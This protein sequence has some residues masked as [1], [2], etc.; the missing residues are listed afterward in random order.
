MNRRNG[1]LY[2]IDDK[3]PFGR[4]LILAIQHALTMFGSTVAVPL[5][6]GPAMGMDAAQTALLISSVMLCSGL[7][8]L[9]QSTFGARLPIIQ[10]V[11]F[12]FLAAFFAIIATGKLASNNW[13]AATMM[14]YIAGTIM[15]GAVVEMLV[16][17]SGLMGRLRRM[18]SPVVVGP[19]IMLIGLALFKHGAPKAGTHWPISGLTMLLVIVCSLGLSRRWRFF[20]IFPI[21]SAICVSCG[22][23]WLLSATGVFGEGHPSHVNLDYVRQSRWLRI[24]P[25]EVVFPWGLP[26]FE[27]GFVIAGL[28][29]YLASMI[30]SFGDYHA[31]SH[32]AGAGD[33]TPKQISRG[34]G[35]EG[36]GCFLTGVFG[37]FSSTSYSENIGLVGL[38]R[39]GSRHVV[40]IAAVLLVFLGL[41]AKFGAFAATIPGPVVGGLYCVLFGLISAVG[42]QQLSKADLSS[43]RNLFIAGFSLFMGLSVPAYFEGGG[44]YSPGWSS[45]SE[46]MMQ[47]IEGFLS[48]FSFVRRPDEWALS[49]KSIIESIGVTGM[50]IAAIVG[51]LLDNLIPGSADE[52]GLQIPSL[53]APEGADAV[54]GGPPG[55]R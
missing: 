3:P 44:T 22:V 50:G 39:V 2:G 29:A 32:M 33:P 41:F 47:W 4:A 20:K 37:G 27:V 25:S 23:C 24:N 14:Q 5:L 38:T 6:L 19:V 31:C 8:T 7:A 54:E 15:V 48:K 34:I 28:A 36:I 43:E 42:V 35:C 10:G 21:L 51:I 9:I 30:E 1:I 55:R 52:R 46:S 17:F 53:I 16:G 12:S 26:K 49:V 45:L 40:Q 13:D 11:S 18:L